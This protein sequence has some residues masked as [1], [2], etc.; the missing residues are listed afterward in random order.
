[1]DQVIGVHAIL[2]CLWIVLLVAALF[3]LGRMYR[4]RQRSRILR[5]RLGVDLQP[6]DT[7]RPRN[8]EVVA[9]VGEN[10]NRA[11]LEH[12]QWLQDE[13]VRRQTESE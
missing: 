12:I 13:K 7:A 4:A 11:I 1:M 6:P 9:G 2:G 8:P 10:P 3:G 5:R